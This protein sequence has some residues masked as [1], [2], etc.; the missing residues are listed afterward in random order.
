MRELCRP[1]FLVGMM[2]C[3]K[4]TMGRHLAALL[5][6]P[7]VDLD[8]EIVRF[9]GRTIP[10]IFASGGDAGFLRVRDGGASARRWRARRAL[11]PQAGASSPGRKTS[12]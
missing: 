12:P 4:S 10:E 1:L 8:E 9:E 2:G 7:F 5:R 3:G 11:S 6:C